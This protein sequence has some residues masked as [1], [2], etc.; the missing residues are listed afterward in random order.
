MTTAKDQFENYYDQSELWGNPPEPYQVEVLADVLAALPGDVGSILDVGCGDGYITN[1]LPD[2]REVVGLDISREAL[3]YVKR[4]TKVG[5]VVELPY[6]DRAF[7]LVMANDVI[8]HLPDEGGVYEKACSE[9]SRVAGRYV[10]ITVPFMENLASGYTRCAACGARYHVNQHQRAYGV[11]EL[12]GLLDGFEPMAFYFTGAAQDAG[13]AVVR[14]VRRQLG[15]MTRWDQAMCPACGAKASVRGVNDDT[16]EA[17]EGFAASLVEGWDGVNRSECLVVYKRKAV[18]EAARAIGGI[19]CGKAVLN[20]VSMTAAGQRKVASELET[21]DGQLIVRAVKPSLIGD[22][23]VWLRWQVGGSAYFY[24]NPEA[25]G[26]GQYLAPS[27]FNVDGVKTLTGVGRDVL[28]GTGEGVLGK[29]VV[30]DL[31]RRLEVA[32]HRKSEAE[33]ALIGMQ[34]RV[35][36]KSS[37]LDQALDRENTLAEK[38]N[39]LEVDLQNAKAELESARERLAEGERSAVDLQNALA[40]VEA[41]RERVR[42]GELVEV[43]LQNLKEEMGV[44]RERADR[45][46]RLAV[47]LQN[48]EEELVQLRVS[49]EEGEKAA[50]ELQ[51]LR[52]ELEDLRERVEEGDSAQVCLQNAEEEIKALREQAEKGELALVELQNAQAEIEQLRE[53]AEEGAKAQVDLQNALA[54]LEIL[55][56]RVEGGE[57]AAVNL[58]NAEAE[59]QGYQSQLSEREDRL[60]NADTTIANLE[61]SLSIAREQIEELEG[62]AEQVSQLSG[63]VIRLEGQLEE[64]ENQALRS[65]RLAVELHETKCVLEERN[66]E[67]AEQA[68]IANEAKE[69]KKQLQSK[70]DELEDVRQRVSRQVASFEERLADAREMIAMRRGWRGAIQC[71]RDRKKGVNE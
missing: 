47:E 21:D 29:G 39:A 33:R 5:S 63:R 1:A 56:H 53:R 40:E 6:G 16:A 48:V 32:E 35:V 12:T 68:E 9:M 46:E 3:K 70:I 25:L 43:S 26:V 17:V 38:A 57:K 52:A 71:L 18:E 7:D 45:A 59:L 19:G 64:R 51:N 15:I 2:D 34:A 66:S 58:R 65:E 13:E 10:V 37:L 23:R 69:L 36:E 24:S 55:R 67:L 28:G 44:I 54:E 11:V 27:W 50:V 30:A 4:E 31:L 60:T 61:S 8:E 41:L 62:R 14:E 42:N 22:R 20:L 49:V